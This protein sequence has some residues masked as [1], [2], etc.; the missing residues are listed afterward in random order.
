[1]NKTDVIL[2]LANF[3]FCTVEELELVATFNE[4]PTRK[5]KANSCS[6]QVLYESH[7]MSRLTQNKD[8]V[9]TRMVP[10]D[11]MTETMN[12]N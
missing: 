6:W 3:K 5:L 10:D 8:L 9:D 4:K 1:M 11:K 12:E 2:V 7:S